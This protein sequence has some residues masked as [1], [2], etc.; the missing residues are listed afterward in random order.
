MS[1]DS[2]TDGHPALHLA[3]DAQAILAR[4]QKT[5]PALSPR[6]AELHMAELKRNRER[7]TLLSTISNML[8]SWMHRQV[9]FSADGGETLEIGAGTL[10]HIPHERLRPGAPYDAIEPF[11]MRDGIS[12]ILMQ[13]PR[14]GPPRAY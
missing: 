8:E 11:A 10:N 5:R 14:S 4:Y 7:E 3:P 6:M 9:A 2:R 13:A 12:G 1:P